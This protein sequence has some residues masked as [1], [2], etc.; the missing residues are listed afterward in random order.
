MNENQTFSR[1]NQPLPDDHVKQSYEKPP[2]EPASPRNTAFNV[3]LVGDPGAVAPNN[4]DPV[5]DTLSARLADDPKATVAYLGD[6]L[7]PE[8]LPPKDH[9]KRE[10]ME[11][12][13]KTLLDPLIDHE[14]EVIVIPG[15]H[16]FKLGLEGG[17]SAASRL[18]DYINTYMHRRVFLPPNGCPGPVVI[19]RANLR[20]IVLNSEWWLQ[21]GP[22]PIGDQYGCR[23][24]SGSDVFVMLEAAIANAQP[25]KQ[26][27]VMTHS[28]LYSDAV[29]GGRFKWH[30]HLFPFRVTRKQLWIPLPF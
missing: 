21:K 26:V 23:A 27:L 13:L 3:Y 6:I 2:Q 19:D 24:E 12:R 9:R 18:E 29:H 30:H 7:Y 14:G 22:R 5:I 15:N 4:Q 17:E 10:L 8:G 25:E 16:D 28:P 11:G 20:M 1:E